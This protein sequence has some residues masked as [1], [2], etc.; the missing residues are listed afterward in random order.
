M[1]FLCLLKIRNIQP[2]TLDTGILDVANTD[3]LAWQG[4]IANG[5]F[6]FPAVPSLGEE[7]TAETPKKWQGR[8]ECAAGRAGANVFCL[9][10]ARRVVEREE[11]ESAAYTTEKIRF[12]YFC[13]I[14]NAD[15]LLK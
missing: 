7:I 5:N 11:K 14:S 1:H 2:L 4:H 12:S 9:Y 3:F 8:G 13:L 15:R 10:Q 6:I